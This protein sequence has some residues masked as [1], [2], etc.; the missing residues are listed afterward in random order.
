M[1]DMPTGLPVLYNCELEYGPQVEEPKFE[2]ELPQDYSVDRCA[3]IDEER[4]GDGFFGDTQSRVDADE[5]YLK[6]NNSQEYLDRTE[7]D[8]TPTEKNAKMQELQEKAAIL[9]R[10]KRILEAYKVKQFNF[11]AKSYSNCHVFRVT[12]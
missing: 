12:I 8:V 3:W 4:C 11:I 1:K 2:D 6:L 10:Q 5:V 7:R 9:S